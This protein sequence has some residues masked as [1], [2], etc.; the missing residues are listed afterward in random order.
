MLEPPK[1]ARTTTQLA[2]TNVKVAKAEKIARI[3]Y[4]EKNRT[5]H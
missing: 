3:A 1:V 4:V 5:A 2:I